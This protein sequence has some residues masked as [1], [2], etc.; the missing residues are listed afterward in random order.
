MQKA[1][2][3]WV[4]WSRG[5][6]VWVLATFLTVNIWSKETKPNSTDDTFFSILAYFTHIRYTRYLYV[7]C[8]DVIWYDMIYPWGKKNVIFHWFPWYCLCCLI[9]KFCWMYGEKRNLITKAEFMRTEL[10]CVYWTGDIQCPWHDTSLLYKVYEQGWDGGRRISCH[11]AG[12]EIFWEQ[13]LYLSCSSIFLHLQW[14]SVIREMA[15]A[16]LLSSSCKEKKLAA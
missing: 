12:V 9:L 4:A 15:D 7:I 5:Q 11:W 8:Y 3:L 13:Q 1:D 2:L 16:H 14:D 10:L 6:E